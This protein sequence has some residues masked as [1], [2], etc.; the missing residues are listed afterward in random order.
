MVF[1][2]IAAQR[3]W[4]EARDEYPFPKHTHVFDNSTSRPNG[5]DDFLEDVMTRGR[6]WEAA[7]RSRNLGVKKRKTITT[8]KN[9][10]QKL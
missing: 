7:S 2:C 8:I 9:N 10:V 3:V 6:S 4:A 1:V 5:P